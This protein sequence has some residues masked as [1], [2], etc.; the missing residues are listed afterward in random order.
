[1]LKTCN[2]C[3]QEFLTEADPHVLIPGTE[4]LN[5][6]CHFAE[7][8]WGRVCSRQQTV[9]SKFVNK[10]YILERVR[11]YYAD[12]QN[13]DGHVVVSPVQVGDNEFDWQPD[14]GVIAREAG[15]QLKELDNE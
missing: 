3:G 10:I 15:E 9:I 7:G 14:E 12:K 5:C 11:F 13:W 2:K 4:G 8:F 6:G 1:M